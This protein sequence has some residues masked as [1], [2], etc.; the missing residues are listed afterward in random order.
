MK[1]RE[2]VKMGFGF[3]IGFYLAGGLLKAVA[4]ASL[5]KMKESK[6]KEEKEENE[7]ER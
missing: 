2:Y 3:G 4:D 1:L 7:D 5:K 6:N